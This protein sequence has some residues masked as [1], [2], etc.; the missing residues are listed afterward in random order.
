MIL[1]RFASLITNFIN[2]AEISRKSVLR[3]EEGGLCYTTWFCQIKKLDMK[4]IIVI[5]ISVKKY[6]ISDCLFPS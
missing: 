5:I 4:S 6:P 3:G 2:I 1:K